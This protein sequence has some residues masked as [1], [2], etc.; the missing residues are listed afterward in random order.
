MIVQL[1]ITCYEQMMQV[2]TRFKFKV[3]SYTI[4]FKWVVTLIEMEILEGCP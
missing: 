3:D 1:K 2:A 4:I